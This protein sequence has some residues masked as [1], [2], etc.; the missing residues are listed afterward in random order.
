MSLMGK[1]LHELSLL[2]DPFFFAVRPLEE[3]TGKIKKGENGLA[4]EDSKGRKHRAEM[5]SR[6]SSLC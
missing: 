5:P 3:S 2:L 6:S 1:I 4:W